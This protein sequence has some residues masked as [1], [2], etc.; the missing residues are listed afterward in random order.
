MSG[1]LIGDV[2]HAGYDYYEIA[3]ARKNGIGTLIGVSLFML[4]FGAILYV[5]HAYGFEGTTLHGMVAVLGVVY[6]GFVLH[7][8]Y[9]ICHGGRWLFAIDNGVLVFE[10]P[11]KG[12]GFTL[13]ITE[14][15]SLTQISRPSSDFPPR[16][17]VISTDGTKYDITD[18]GSLHWHKV[19]A[20]LLD[21]NPSIRK[22]YNTPL[23][24]LRRQNY[25]R[26]EQK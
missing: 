25:A 24:V 1:R 22:E 8:V 2:D 5:A 11:F 18:C 14:I 15:V 10:S 13:K 4:L 23:D 19:F 6:L 20:K 17:Y 9:L 12:K 7:S 16:L 21:L 26:T 3:D